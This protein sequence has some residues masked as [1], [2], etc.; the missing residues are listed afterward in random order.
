MT[1]WRSPSSPRLCG[2]SLE[3]R[4]DV[5]HRR[6]GLGG[7]DCRR[8]GWLAALLGYTRSSSMARGD[9][10]NIEEYVPSTMPTS[11]AS[12]KAVSDEPPSKVSEA[13]MNTAPIPVLM[14]RGIV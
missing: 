8:A 11:N 14:V 9:A 1:F 6:T 13:R 5:A 2:L 3:L 7:A 12:A 10:R 4:H